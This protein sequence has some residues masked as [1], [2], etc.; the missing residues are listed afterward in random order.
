MVSARVR[1]I[2]RFGTIT[3]F[4]VLRNIIKG[5]PELVSGSFKESGRY[6]NKIL[7]KYPQDDSAIDR[8]ICIHQQ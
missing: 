1:F 2:F 5:H 8:Q 3:G 7:R 6:F 4:D